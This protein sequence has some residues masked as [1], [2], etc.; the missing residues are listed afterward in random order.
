MSLLR[1]LTIYDVIELCADEIKL[2]EWLRSYGVLSRTPTICGKCGSGLKP[3]D[4][5]GKAGY[6][7]VDQKC[8]TRTSATVGGILEGSKLSYKD[9]FVML[10][11]LY[12]L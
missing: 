8:R 11:V 2:Q 9:F 5:R 3:S 1:M 7:C 10:D 4:H 12:P 6:I